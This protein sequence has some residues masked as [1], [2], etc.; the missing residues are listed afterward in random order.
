ME[1]WRYISTLSQPRYW[2]ELSGQLHAV[3][4][5]SASKKTF[6]PIDRRLFGHQSWS[7]MD[8]EEKGLWSCR[9]SN[10]GHSARSLVTVLAEL[11]LTAKVVHVIHPP[12]IEISFF[13]WTQLIRL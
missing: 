1:E 13:I 12:G 11:Y 2:M 5:L 4:A 7:G 9:A 8:A 3:A 10:P 6:L